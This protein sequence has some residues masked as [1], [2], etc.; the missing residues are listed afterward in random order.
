MTRVSI[1][2]EPTDPDNF[3]FHAMAREKQARGRTA[4]EALDALNAQLPK[5]ESG[6][7]VIVQNLAPDSFFGEE[8]R[9]RL[10]QLM[11]QRREALVGGP[12]LSPDDE[13]ELERLVDAET[14][15]SMSRAAALLQLVGR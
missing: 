13:A 12:A 9:R 15:A 11:A 5:D 10:E 6:T 4:G 8:P 7:L 1:Y 3:S 14:R 2:Q